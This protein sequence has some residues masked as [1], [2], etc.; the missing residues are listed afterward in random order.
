MLSNKFPGVATTESCACHEEDK[1]KDK[2]QKKAITKLLI[3]IAL[4]TVFM[5][6]EAIGKKKLDIKQHKSVKG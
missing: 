5:T 3:A 6:G 4:G 2:H 1:E